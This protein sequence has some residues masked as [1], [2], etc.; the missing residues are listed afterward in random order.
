MPY[1]IQEK[2]I[3]NFILRPNVPKHIKINFILRAVVQCAHTTGVTAN[4]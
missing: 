2:F 1:A 4:F 3:Y